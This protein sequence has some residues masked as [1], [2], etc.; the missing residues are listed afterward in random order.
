MS[1]KTNALDGLREQ[2]TEVVAIAASEAG[3]LTEDEVDLWWDK[4]SDAVQDGLDAA[5]IEES[6]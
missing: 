2:L 6:A 3:G 1:R 5:L 4:L